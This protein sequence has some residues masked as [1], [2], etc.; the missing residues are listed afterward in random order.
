LQPVLARLHHILEEENNSLT[1]QTS[2]LRDSLLESLP[3]G[4]GSH[5]TADVLHSLGVSCD[6][7]GSDALAVAWWSTA[8]ARVQREMQSLPEPLPSAPPARLLFVWL[9]YDLVAEGAAPNVEVASA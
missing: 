9:G 1:N 2:F 7:D 5:F 3:G 8:R 4:L 6:D